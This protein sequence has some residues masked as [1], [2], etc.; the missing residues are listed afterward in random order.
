MSTAA[1][2]ATRRGEPEPSSRPL[3]APWWRAVEDS[4]RLLFEHAG[5]V[6][7]LNGRAVGALLPTLVPLLDGT[8]TRAG[9]RRDP[10]R[11]GRGTDREGPHAARRARPA[12]R[13]SG[14]CGSRRRRVLCRAV[15]SCDA[16]AAASMRWRAR[17]SRSSDRRP[18]EPRLRACWR[19]LVSRRGSWALWTDPAS[20]GDLIVAAPAAEEAEQ[21]GSLNERRLR[22]ATPWLAL[23]PTDGRFAAVGP[24]FVPGQTAC[25]AC[26]LLRRGAT[27]GYEQDFALLERRPVRAPMPAA[28]S[29]IAAGLAALICL[30]WLGARDPDAAGSP[31]RTRA[32][33]HPRSYAA[34]G[35]PSAALSSVRPGIAT[36]QPV[37]QGDR[38]WSCSTARRHRSLT[39][40]SGWRRPSLRWS[41]SCASHPRSWL[42]QM[43]RVSTRLRASSRAQQ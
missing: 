40:S 15:C 23:L 26:Y 28:T 43:R 19:P 8:H 35:A 10:R 39:R 30:R 5:Q 3:L 17:A 24:L 21:L 32:T 27:S 36:T 41:A 13:R 33:G 22:D 7:E 14:G 16:G 12:R 20:D 42:P 1:E 34:S 38:C 18:Q 11:G 6:V 31:V 2:Q 37:V 25:H 4:D 29:T 9:D